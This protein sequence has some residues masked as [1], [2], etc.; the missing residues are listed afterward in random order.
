M[1]LGYAMDTATR[2][3]PVSIFSS[4]FLGVVVLRRIVGVFA[5]A[6]ILLYFVLIQVS[7]ISLLLLGMFRQLGINR[8]LCLF[9]LS[10]FF[11][12]LLLKERYITA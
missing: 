12:L 5:H 7:F 1:D 2:R 3:K 10:F 9:F 8:F 11:V 4:S 6:P